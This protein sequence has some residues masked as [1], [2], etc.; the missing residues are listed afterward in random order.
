MQILEGD[1]IEE[2]VAYAESVANDPV[3]PRR[4]SK[5]PVK[6]DETTPMVFKGDLD[7]SRP[8]SISTSVKTIR[9]LYLPVLY[10]L[11]AVAEPSY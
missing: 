4:V 11:R 2:G 7:E 8:S 6:V 5:M 3:E 1:P 9:L 10:S